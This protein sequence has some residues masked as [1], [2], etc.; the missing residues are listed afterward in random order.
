MPP[1]T[2]EQLLDRILRFISYRLRTQKEVQDKLKTL[3]ASPAQVAQLC[4]VLAEH[5]LL[6]DEKVIHPMLKEYLENRG[7][8]LSRIKTMLKLKGFSDFLIEDALQEYIEDNQEFSEENTALALL[9]RKYR[10]TGLPEDNAK[11]LAFLG[12]RGFSY[13]TA[14]KALNIY[15]KTP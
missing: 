14:S 2:D 3:G 5:G 4:S 9:E 6:D 15:K 1:R 11:A 10:N 7:L 8:G 13:G 12:R